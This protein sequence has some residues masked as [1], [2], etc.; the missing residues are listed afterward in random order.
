MPAFRPANHPLI[1][2]LDIVILP[3]RPSHFILQLLVRIQRGV[4]L[5]HDLGPTSPHETRN[6][7]LP[8]PAALVLLPVRLPRHRARV[9]GAH[10]RTCAAGLAAP[11]EIRA[12][13]GGVRFDLLVGYCLRD[14]VLEELQV[15]LVG[16][17]VCCEVLDKR[18]CG[19][20]GI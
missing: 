20:R 2:H 3:V 4:V 19:G 14:Y 11:A 8:A 13:R 15:V 9:L 7:A 6:A 16:D 5:A 1:S 10:G 18:N 17:C 12:R